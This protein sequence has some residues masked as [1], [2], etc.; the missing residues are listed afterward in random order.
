MTSAHLTM[1]SYGIGQDSWT[2]LAKLALDRE[3]RQRYAPGRLIVVASDTGNEHP[4]TYAHNEC[5]K[6]FCESHGIEYVHITRE[7]GFHSH[8]WQTLQFYFRE[9][10]NIA[11]KAYPKTCTDNL[12]IKPIY[13]FLENYIE[14][15]FG[16]KAGRKKGIK[17][18][19]EA[20][21]KIRVL[22]G[23]AKGEE[24]RVGKSDP[25][26]WMA[27]SL[28]KVYPLIDIG[29][30]RAECQ[31]WLKE[32]QLPVPP[33]SNCIFCPFK[34]MIEVLWTSRFLPGQFAEWVELEQNKIN[35]WAAKGTPAK[36]NLGVNGLKLLPEYLAAAIT[37]Y[38]HMSD[39]ELN[40]Y[41]MSHG[42]LCGS[43]Y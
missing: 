35:A 30:G 16:F 4:D 1:L 21:G 31:Q 6:R 36:E 13:K 43:A 29:Y 11:S 24:G 32:N 10:S 19:A 27:K 42:H 12:K 17:E 9:K 23:I 5:S 39:T 25:H 14:R 34:S 37:K 22:I 26:P 8:G 18:F 33:P 2:I 41:R 3:F 40:D 28:E 15:V 7:M 38:G 20:N